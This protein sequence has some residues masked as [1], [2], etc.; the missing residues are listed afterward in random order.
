MN[1]AN[2]DPLLLHP[3]MRAAVRELAQLLAEADIPLRL[4]EGWRG[5]DRQAELYLQGRAP[6]HGTPGVHVTQSM[7]WIGRHQYGL[8]SD[9]VFWVNG[10]TWVEPE[11]GM[12]DE[13]DKLAP[14]AGLVSVPFERPHVQLAGV[15]LSDLLLG[16][17]PDGG[18]LSWRNNFVAAVATWKPRTEGGFTWR[19]APPL[20]PDTSHV[21]EL[22]A[23]G[24]AWAVPPGYV[25]DEE[26]GMCLIS[27]DGSL[28]V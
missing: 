21:D 10:W 12:W 23:E 15:A 18:D 16:K 26:R 20:P 24:R 2:R 14:K 22:T 11:H 3:T 5:P 1:Q 9:F 28:R 25:F 13:Y 19:S 7:P 17:Y 27:G 6:G 8:A 4:Y